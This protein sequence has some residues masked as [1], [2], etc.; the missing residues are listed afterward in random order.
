MLALSKYVREKF[1][2][3]TRKSYFMQEMKSRGRVSQG[4]GGRDIVWQPE[5]RRNDLTWGS[6]NPNV[7]SFPQV[8]MWASAKLDYK[9]CWMGASM[10]EIEV[11]AL[12]DK[13]ANYFKKLQSVGDRCMED[14]NIRFA[15]HLFRDGTGTNKIDGLESFGS[16][17]AAAT[18]EPIGLPNDLYAGLSTTLGSEGDWSD[19]TSGGWPRCGSDPDACDYEYHYFSP[20]IVDYNNSNLVVD[21]TTE[22][23]NWDDCWSY[24]LRYLTT[25]TGIINGEAPDVIIIDPD[26]LRR[27]ENSMK[28]YQ[29]FD[30]E[31]TSKTLDPGIRVAKWEGIKLAT[32][33]GVPAGCGYG[34][35]FRKLELMC[36]GDEFIKTMEQTDIATADRLFRLSWHGNLVCDSPTHFPMLKAVSTAGT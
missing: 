2:L 33:W 10:S 15:P 16:Y 20:L 29:K 24:A 4:N 28:N 13:S 19:P 9:T 26:L 35:N 14:F 17:S 21:S 11:L 27:A 30:L 23:A 31:D 25:Y 5:K 12:Q 36:M 6:G 8:N 1:A 22:S 18:Y 34:V 3:P 32:E 7:V